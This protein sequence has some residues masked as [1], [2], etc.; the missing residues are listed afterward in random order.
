VIIIFIYCLDEQ[1]KITLLS[2]GYKFLKQEFMKDK[3]SISVF[4][5]KP[6]VQFDIVDKNAYFISD[7]LNF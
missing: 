2:K 5:F 7:K 6:N 1:T 4:E 3:Q